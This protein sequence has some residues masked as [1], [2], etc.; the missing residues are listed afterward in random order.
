MT[1][2]RDRTSW[3]SGGKLKCRVPAT[4]RAHPLRLVLLGAPGVGK[5]T[6]AELLSQRLGPCQ[7]STGDL[8]RYAQQESLCAMGEA[9]AE[10]INLMRRGELVPDEMVV[11]MVVERCGCLRCRGGFL[12]D[13][14]PRTIRQAQA[15]DELLSGN[16]LS[17]DAVFNYEMPIDTIV[18]RLSGRRMCSSCKAVF[19]LETK[20]PRQPGQCDH[21]R[22][23]LVQRE[24]DRPETVRIRML[25]YEQNTAPLIEFYERRGLLVRISAQGSAEQIYLRSLQFVPS[26]CL[27]GAT[28]GGSDPK[29]TRMPIGGGLAE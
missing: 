9:L 19:H 13:G 27:E 1:A 23:A 17:L 29:N 25:A 16:R 11:R 12:L 14:F 10:A 3:L 18:A 22:G 15:L 21:C 4:P 20:P 7:L 28:P 2:H 24:D 5:G 8:F 6:Q 26:V